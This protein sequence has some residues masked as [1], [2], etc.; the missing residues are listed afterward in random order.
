MGRGSQAKPMAWHR[1]WTPPG[2]RTVHKFRC[3]RLEPKPTLTFALMHHCQ[4]R[5]TA[6]VG[7]AL[8]DSATDVCGLGG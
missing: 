8:A 5:T 6:R 4:Q 1:A 3:T 2:T 7:D